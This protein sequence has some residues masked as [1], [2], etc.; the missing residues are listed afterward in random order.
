MD[1]YYVFKKDDVVIQS[2]KG[3][4]VPTSEMFEVEEITRAEFLNL[5]LPCKRIDGVWTK[6]NEMPEIEYPVSE[7]ED[8]VT[9]GLT[10]E[11]KI[12]ALEEQLATTQDAVDFIL[13]NM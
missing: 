4:A 5:P 3:G 10:P 6:V 1:R 13:M 12:Q 9:P 7:S 2:I 11:E 8:P